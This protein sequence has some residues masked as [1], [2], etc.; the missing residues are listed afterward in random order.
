MLYNIKTTV[1]VG[2]QLLFYGINFA[3]SRYMHK[4]ISYHIINYELIIGIWNR[5][6]SYLAIDERHGQNYAITF[7]TYSYNLFFF[8][9]V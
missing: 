5:F 7:H 4:K 2:I 3:K 9:I 6:L 8:F 1:F